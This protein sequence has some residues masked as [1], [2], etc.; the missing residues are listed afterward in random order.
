MADRVAKNMRRCRFSFFRFLPGMIACSR[1]SGPL[2]APIVPLLGQCPW[3]GAKGKWTFHIEKQ[4]NVNWAVIFFTP[5]LA[6]LIWVVAV[7]LSIFA[8]NFSPNLYLSILIVGSGLL[9]LFNLTGY[10]RVEE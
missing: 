6:A 3:C 7:W 5:I 9:Y 8:V 1:C 2:P 4:V 10:Y